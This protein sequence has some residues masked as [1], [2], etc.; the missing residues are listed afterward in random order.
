[1]ALIVG[2]PPDSAILSEFNVHSVRDVVHGVYFSF[3]ENAGLWWEIGLCKGLLSVLDYTQ[4]MLWWRC[5]YELISLVSDLLPHQL[6]L[7]FH[8]LSGGT[9]GVDSWNDERHVCGCCLS[10]ISRVVYMV[11][12]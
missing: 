11:Y 8:S 6:R 7:P 10:E 12:W 2:D 1:M 9:A 4:A 3:P 5:A